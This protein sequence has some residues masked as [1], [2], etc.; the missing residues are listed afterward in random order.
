[1]RGLTAAIVLAAI[2]LLTCGLRAEEKTGGST[3]TP[4]PLLPGIDAS[5]PTHPR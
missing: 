3:G 1:M 4:A 2:A 5:R